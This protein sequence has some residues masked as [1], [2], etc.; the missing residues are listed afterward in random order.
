MFYH[1]G[2][3]AGNEHYMTDVLN[4]SG[5]GGVEKTWVRIDDK[6]VAVRH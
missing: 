5:N 4:L 6:A 2:E 3:R 1:H